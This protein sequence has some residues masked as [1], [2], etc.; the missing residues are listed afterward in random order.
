MWDYYKIQKESSS[1]QISAQNRCFATIIKFK[2]HFNVNSAE[3]E[4]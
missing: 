4:F 2:S 1:N 3:K